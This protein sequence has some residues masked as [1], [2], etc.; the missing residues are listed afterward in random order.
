M[1]VNEA[2]SDWRPCKDVTDIT[3]LSDAAMEACR[4]HWNLTEISVFAS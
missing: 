3:V 1:L 4:L 2:G